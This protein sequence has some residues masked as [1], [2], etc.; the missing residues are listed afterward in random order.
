MLKL[1]AGRK[2]CFGGALMEWWD[3]DALMEWWDGDG[4]ALMLVRDENALLLERARVRLLRWIVAWTGLSAAWFLSDGDPGGHS[5]AIDL[6]VA[7]WR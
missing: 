1:A 3:G 6:R 5:A 4:T 2:G 7:S